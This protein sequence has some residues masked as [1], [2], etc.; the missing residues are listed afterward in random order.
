[1][2]TGRSRPEASTGP[3]GTCSVD[4]RARP[5]DGH[6]NAEL[7]RFLA[8]EFGVPAAAVA[9]VSGRTSR[10]KL[11]RIEGALTTPPWFRREVAGPVAPCDNPDSGAG[12]R[13]R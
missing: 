6:A 3:D 2:R 9:I 8:A 11:V 1:M 10:N 12:G 5:E 7:E 4:L 13:R